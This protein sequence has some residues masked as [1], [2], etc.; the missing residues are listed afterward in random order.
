MF[1]NLGPLSD[2]LD[3][4]EQFSARS[5]L[6]IPCTCLGKCKYWKLF[7]KVHNLQGLD[8]GQKIL[9]GYGRN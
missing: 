8:N 9:H 5:I 1:Y 6:F 7:K 2:L 3:M 4:R